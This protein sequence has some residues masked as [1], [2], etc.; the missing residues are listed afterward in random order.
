MPATPYKT[1][2]ST[3]PWYAQ[4]LSFACTQCGNCCTG[5]PGYVWFT[6]QEA[7]RIAAY[8]GITPAAFHRQYAHQI[9]SQW[10][11][12]EHKTAYGH[13]CVFLKRDDAGKALC[14]IY[15]VR[16]QQCRTWPFWHENLQT[17]AAWQRAARTCPG[18]DHGKLY[19]IDQIRIIRD[20]DATV[21]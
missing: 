21:R 6:P 10:S 15:S 2:A 16:P 17:H 4:G 20:G 11:L 18:I 3:Q 1:D 13:D 12:N 14:S 7:D 19:P 8:L 5:P 9:D